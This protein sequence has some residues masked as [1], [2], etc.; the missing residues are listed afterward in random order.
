MEAWRTPN[1]RLAVTFPFQHGKSLL[2]SQ[3]FPAWVL[4]LWPETR[5]A[6]ASYEETFASSFGAKVRDIVQRYGPA[7]GIHLRD[8]TNAKG[9]W[10]IDGYGG[11]MVCKGRGGALV[12][13]P[14]DLLLLDDMLKN[15]EEALSPTILENLWDWYCTVAYSRLGPTAP[16]IAVGTR[17]GPKDLFGRWEAESKVGGDKF[18]TITFKAIAENNDILGRQIGEALWPERVPLERL[19]KVRKTRPRWFKCCWQGEPEETIGLHFQPREWP[20]YTDV[21]DAWR[22]HNGTHWVSYRKVDCTIVIAV[23]WAQAGK[24]RSDKTAIVVAALTADGMMLVLHVFSDRLRY[25]QNAPCL[26][27]RCDMWRPPP[28]ADPLMIASDDDMLSDAMV[29]ECRRQENEYGYRR[30]P[31]IMRLGIRSRSKLVRAQSAIVRSQNGLFL[32]PSVQQEWFEECAD[33]LASFTG[34]EGAEDDIADC[35][36]ILGRIA[37]DYKPGDGSDEYESALGAAGQYFADNSMDSTPM[38]GGGYY[39]GY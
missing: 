20:K 39:G 12:G 21:G 33:Q 19:L 15:S 9:E 18:K 29:L 32:M 2:C 30:I 22:A 36:G 28:E 17:W 11:G 5:I 6:L 24:K 37:D 7:F 34:E 26:A 25:E 3:Y 4:L 8:D 13:R 31:E 16:I 27:D 23:D 14:C 38:P 10:V 35:F 1:S